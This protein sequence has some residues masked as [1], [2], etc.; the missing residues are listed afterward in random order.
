M[1]EGQYNQVFIAYIPEGWQVGEGNFDN[2]VEKMEVVRTKI[3]LLILDIGINYTKVDLDVKQISWMT[4]K[5]DLEDCLTYWFES[6]GFLPNSGTLSHEPTGFGIVDAN[7]RVRPP[8]P[9]SDGP[10]P[11]H[12][13]TEQAKPPR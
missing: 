3:D 2:F 8:P 9:Q 10:T 11:R 4:N 7:P 13:W 6:N 12:Q 5:T 1:D